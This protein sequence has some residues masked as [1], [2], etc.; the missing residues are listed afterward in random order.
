MPTSLLSLL[1]SLAMGSLLLS[2]SLPLLSTT[3][4]AAKLTSD[5]DALYQLSLRW[6]GI[7]N[8]ICDNIDSHRLSTG[9][10]ILEPSLLTAIAPRLRPH[11]SSNAI[12]I[13]R[14]GA[15]TPRFRAP[16]DGRFC[17][18][19]LPTSLFAL[20][21][22]FGLSFASAPQEIASGCH[23]LSPITLTDHPLAPTILPASVALPILSRHLLYLD[24]SS[25]IRY[26]ALDAHRIREHQ[27]VMNGISALH[28]SLAHDELTTTITGTI[29]H[30]QRNILR[31]CTTSLARLHPSALISALSP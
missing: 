28:F 30:D 20:L 26:I 11:D 7:V 19:H 21:H 4:T 12:A 23:H 22:R 29:T 9:I 25:T 24:Q 17:G 13:L 3:S 10:N 8:Q 6:E 27:P 2:L 31:S 16:A 15:A 5:I 14:I 1:A 18:E